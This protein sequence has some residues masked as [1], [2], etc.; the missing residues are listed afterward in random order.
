MN[1]LVAKAASIVSVVAVALTV[2]TSMLETI[3]SGLVLVV[4]LIQCL[5]RLWP[6]PEVVRVDR[7]YRILV[8]DVGL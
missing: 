5:A 4:S 3:W 2:A 7:N 1:G 8:K 6:F